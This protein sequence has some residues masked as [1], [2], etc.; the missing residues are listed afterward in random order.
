[1]KLLPRLLLLGLVLP[2]TGLCAAVLIAGYL[3]HESLVR[4]VEQRLLAQAAVESVSLFDGP[5]HKPH[6]HLPASPLAA[7][8]AAF[9]PASALYDPHGQLVIAAPA[10][11]RLPLRPPAS[12]TP[13]HPRIDAPDAHSRALTVGVERPGEGVYTLHLVASLQPVDATM[14]SF[15]RSVGAA[16]ALIA[17]LLFAV[18]YLQARGLSRRIREIIEFVP[19]V[20]EARAPRATPARGADELAELGAAIA[21]ATQFLHHQQSAQE[22]FLANAAHQ[23][24][25]PLT[26]LRTE[27]DLALRRPRGAPELRES[28]EQARNEVDRLTLL[29]RK[30]LDLETLRVQPIDLHEVD[31]RQVLH[32]VTQRHAEAALAKQ[33]TL[34][35]TG[36]TQLTCTCDPLLISQALENLVD[37]AVRFA[38]PSS[39]VEIA[40]SSRAGA[41]VLSVHDDG[42]GIP[43]GERARVFEPF[44]RG[45][46][47]GSQTGLGLAFAADVARKHGGRVALRSVPLGTTFELELPSVATRE[48]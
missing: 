36:D 29:A 25:T 32:D 42:P 1:M 9:A 12:A 41:C 33:V 6:V 38:P 37:N 44:F 34:Q 7:E 40:G 23:L 14:R 24:R 45:S 39:V 19:L 4:D 5:D 26:V 20:R 48:A 17:A 30:L 10:N 31:L 43:E 22:R 16:V 27:I 15:Y 3:F 8:V 35:E 11:V 28:L 13:G 18:L 46:A 47:E 2:M 21:E